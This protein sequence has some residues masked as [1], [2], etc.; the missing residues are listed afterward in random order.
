MSTE[1]TTTPEIEAVQDSLVLTHNTEPIMTTPEP[2]HLPVLRQLGVALGLLIF[3]FLTS[4]TGTVIAL[5][6][7]PTNEESDIIVSAKLVES[8]ETPHT[9]NPFDSVGI[10]GE[11]GFV[12]DVREQTILFNKN[13]DVSLPLASIT[14]LMTALVAYELLEDGSTIDVTINAIKADGD[15]GMRDGE[16]FSLKNITDMVLIA[17][18]NDGAMALAEAA[19]NSIEGAIDP[20]ELFVHAMNIRAEELGLLETH[21]YNPTGLDISQTEPG[22]V[23]SARDVAHL[24]EY[25]I[26]N[27]PSVVNF[28][29]LES[30][31]VYAETGEHFDIENTNSIISE[32]DGLIA[33]KTGYTDL[34]GGNLVIAFDAGLARPIIV[35]VLGSTYNGRF[36]D[37][38]TL[39]NAARA[40]IT[41]GSE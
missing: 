25:I 39:A 40:F 29:T 33:S 16:V 35:V 7:K 34:A 4:Y 32:I 27:Y 1:H 38:L 8:S 10:E 19:G 14:K 5:L 9:E 21:F 36:S 26:T 2:A 17:S 22:A 12:W 3:V 31:R 28:T 20:N 11:A 41:T 30:A 37:V 23:S 13:A 24:L 6:T 15:S 18:S